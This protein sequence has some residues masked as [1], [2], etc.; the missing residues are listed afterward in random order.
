MAYIPRFNAPSESDKLWIQ[1]GSGGYNHCIYVTGNSVLP[2]CT[3]YAWGRFCE[4]M[5]T[6]T[7]NLSIDN[8]MRWYGYTE[9]GY[10]RGNSPKLGAVACWYGGTDGGHVA[11]VEKINS[12]GSIE[13]SNSAWNGDRFYSQKLYPPAYTWSD[14][15]TLQGFIYNPSVNG[16]SAE[17]KLTDYLKEA[18]SHIGE[19]LMQVNKSFGSNFITKWSGGFLYECAN[20]V[21]GLIDVIFP[22]KAITASD[23]I[24]L[25]SKA[26]MGKW[27]NGPHFGTNTVPKCGDIVSFRYEKSAKYKD[28]YQSDRVGIVVESKNRKIITIEGDINNH[29]KQKSYS[30]E[31]RMIHGYYRPDWSKVNASPDSI[32]SF[33]SSGLSLYNTVNTRKDASIREVC[34]MSDSYKP[35]LLPSGLKLSVINYTTL[36]SDVFDN[37][38]IPG[39]SLISGSDDIVLD[40]IENQNARIIIRY[41]VNKGMYISMAVGF[42]A[43]IQQESGFDPGAINSYSGASGLCQWLGSRRTAMINAVGSDWKTNITGQLDYLW[44]ELNGAESATLTELKNKVKGNTEDDV[45]ESTVIVLY[46]FERPGKSESV[47]SKRKENARKL[48]DNIVIKKSSDLS[49][50][51]KHMDGKK[52]N[53]PSSVNQ[54]GITGNNT[55]YPD[56]FNTW[57]ESTVQR[58]VADLWD[59]KGRKSSYGIATIDGY[60]IVA[61]TTIFGYAGD[62]LQVVL[63]DG[64]EF[65]AV[66]GD[67]K[68][69]DPSLNGES[70]NKYGHAFDDGTIDVIEW[71]ATHIPVNISDWKGKKVAYIINGGSYI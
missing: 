60:Y 26:N 50:L 13:T 40:K 48:W 15:F 6:T 18:R 29:V 22:K 57:A 25:G 24:R 42:A 35:K 2:N 32:I 33:G 58:K 68:G 64:S 12:D 67:S 31:T 63:E 54:S 5:G 36:L 19:N 65:N 43:N 30:I 45:M 10:N 49:S 20:K 61:T 16:G 38:L 44:S 37:I 1:I 46:K 52:I 70:G 66:I 3:G 14:Y 28:H 34:Y 62:K 71:E 23:I 11:I 39:T 17:D 7:C 53:I 55:F 51:K 41:L 9:D 27:I 59:S 4:I 69:D 47:E 21:G 56:Y 8:A